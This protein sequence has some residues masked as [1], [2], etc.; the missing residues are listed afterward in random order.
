MFKNTTPILMTCLFTILII[1]IPSYADNGES[2]TQ[3]SFAGISWTDNIKTISKK[4]EKSGTLTPLREQNKGE[5]D[6]YGRALRNIHFDN[7]SPDDWEIER[8]YD[9]AC[10]GLKNESLIY[11]LNSDAVNR[12]GS[13]AGASFY[14]SAQTGKLLHYRIYFR[15]KYAQDIYD[16]SVQK[17]GKQHAMIKG[18]RDKVQM[19]D[20]KYDYPDKWAYWGSN[21]ARL[22]LQISGRSSDD[23]WKALY[24][25]TANIAEVINTCETVKGAQ[26][27]NARSKTNLF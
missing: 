3:I 1:T 26:D 12:S 22:Y 25:N 17:Y 13:I 9:K 14:F 11:Q 16:S 21:T 23:A 8:R 5:R 2:A 4:L 24:I 20:G 18:D 6:I 15:N 7:E 19:P 27:S 10:N